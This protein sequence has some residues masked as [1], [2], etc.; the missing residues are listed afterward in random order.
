MTL[1]PI[2]LITI[3][4]GGYIAQFL[5][6]YKKWETVDGGLGSGT[7]PTLPDA[8]PIECIKAL[9]TMPYGLTGLLI[10]IALIAILIIALIHMSCGGISGT[11]RERNFMYSDKGTYGTSGFM[12]DKERDEILEVCDVRKSKGI[13]LGKIGKK[14]VLLPTESRLNRNLAVYGASG[15]MKSRA[16]IRNAVLQAVRREESMILTDPKSELYEDLSLYLEEK[17][18][19]V[20][21]F[22]LVNPEY[23]DG[24]NCL[25]EIQGSELMAQVFCDVVIKNT[26]SIKADHF[27]DNAEQCLLKAL[28]LYVEQNYEP[29]N[30]NIGEVYNLL[31]TSNEDK[32]NAMFSM[33]PHSH[34]AYA[35]YSIFKQASDTVRSGVII[36][37]ASRIQVFQNKMIREITA[38]DDIDLV[39]PG[40]EKCAYF[41]ITSDQDSTFDFLSSLMFSF[42]FIRLVRYAD[43]YCDGG[44]LPVHV[45]FLCDEFPNIGTIVDLKKKISTIR[46]RNLSIS[47]LVFQNLPQLQNR[48]P[49]NEWQEIL[50]NCDVQLFLGCT[51]EIGAKFV[52][53]RTGL[54]TVAVSSTA[55]QLNSWRVTNYTPEYRETS[56]IGKRNVLT[57]DEVLRLPLN[58]ALVII[59]GQKV[60]KVEKFDYTLHPDAKKLK[61]QKASSYVPK[62]RK[63]QEEQIPTDTKTT[64]GD[65]GDTL[66]TPKKP[67]D[68]IDSPLSG[69]EKKPDNK[70]SAP[71]EVTKKDIDSILS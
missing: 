43:T 12:T 18:Y 45:N 68:N 52:A 29:E 35:P 7:T 33:L 42:L 25:S 2:V 41:V 36:G 71:R 58:E 54:A 22:N 4:G 59:R 40:K 31:A 13:I 20:R 19:K 27:W 3:Y 24:W 1:P 38:H 26:G 61:K 23:S 63:T 17:G 62:W 56:S 28:V 44:K 5:I 51:D 69:A 67:D 14:A 32:L 60:L 64:S 9:F 57:P 21:V 53:D 16:Y 66:H 15:S 46:S 6:N 30:R 11:D 39:L 48:Y 50:G 47:G 37:L 65:K 70:T 55:K 34:P 49:N 10:C 8:S